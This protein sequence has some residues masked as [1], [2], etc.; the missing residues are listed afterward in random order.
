MIHH[1]CVDIA[2]EYTAD[3]QCEPFQ[4]ITH[5]SWLENESSRISALKSIEK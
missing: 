1:V 5:F 2:H 3:Y 4:K